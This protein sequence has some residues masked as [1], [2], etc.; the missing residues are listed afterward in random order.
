MYELFNNKLIKRLKLKCSSMNVLL[1]HGH[2]KQTADGGS[3]KYSR[4]PVRGRDRA[5]LLVGH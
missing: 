3:F 2:N 5:M 4:S 1:L